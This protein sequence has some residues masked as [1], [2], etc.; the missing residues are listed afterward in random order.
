MRKIVLASGNKG[1]VR[2]I[3]QILAG[4]DIEVVPQTE[5]GVPEAEETGLTFTRDDKLGLGNALCQIDDPRC[6]RN[7]TTCVG[8]K[9][10]GRATMQSA[11]SVDPFVFYRP[12]SPAL[13]SIK[14]KP[15]FIC[16][17]VNPIAKTK[18]S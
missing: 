8:V 4:L 6:H 2:E 13:G 10:T 17:F 14:L 7:A 5:F 3:N 11:G 9:R 15:L 12:S 16:C 18:S 1:K